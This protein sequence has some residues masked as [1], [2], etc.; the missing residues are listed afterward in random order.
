M[1][2][3][4]DLVNIVQEEFG[5]DSVVIYDDSQAEL[6]QVTIFISLFSSDHG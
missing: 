5:Q 2:N 6:S 1:S 4:Q 3:F